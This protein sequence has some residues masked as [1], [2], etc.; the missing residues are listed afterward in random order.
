MPLFIALGF[1]LW[2]KDF[3]TTPYIRNNSVLKGTA[4]FPFDLPPNQDTED[5]QPARNDNVRLE[6]RFSNALSEPIQLIA[7]LEQPRVFHFD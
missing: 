6:I 3:N 2:N 7:F 1:Q 5:I 4:I